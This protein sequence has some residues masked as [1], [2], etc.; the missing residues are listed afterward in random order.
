VKTIL[1]ADDQEL[2]RDLVRAV[3][4][5]NPAYQ[6]HEA[7][8]GAEALALA[9]EHHPDLVLLDV[10]MPEMTG[11]EVCVRLKGSPD[12]RD[13]PILLMSGMDPEDV[14]GYAL[15]ASAD[16]FFAKPFKAKAVLG[17]MKELLGE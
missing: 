14:E 5:T 8:N 7:V 1:V 9:R 4:S 6:V 17:R 12:T 13:I 15:M 10:Q 11:P 3:L 2:T 16:G